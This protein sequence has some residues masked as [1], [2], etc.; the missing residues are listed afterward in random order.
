MSTVESNQRV[1]EERSTDRLLRVVIALLLRQ[2]EDGAPSLKRQ[3]EILSDL[4]MR[5]VEI[6]ETL[7][8]T[9]RHVNKELTALRKNRKREE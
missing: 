9:S 3:I 8:R 5:P 4:G 1:T 2:K 6:A 7:G